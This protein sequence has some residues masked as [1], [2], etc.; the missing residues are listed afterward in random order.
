MASRTVEGIYRDGVV[1]LTGPAPRVAPETRVLITF[2]PVE[3]AS[4]GQG[5]GSEQSRRAALDRLMARLEKGIDF[6]GPPY[7][8]R[9]EL[10][11]RAYKFD[12]GPG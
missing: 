3:E 5:C 10:Y 9:E 2:P 7:P 4:E 6:G 12:Q 11:D 8:G 1:E